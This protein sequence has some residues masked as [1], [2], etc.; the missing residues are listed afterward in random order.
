MK[1]G[2]A[3]GYVAHFFLLDAVERKLHYNDAISHLFSFH[4]ALGKADQAEQ[5]DQVRQ[6]RRNFQLV[7]RKDETRAFE[8][9]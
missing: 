3:S 1:L 2:L 4:M 6:G 7:T 8:C 9:P 5:A